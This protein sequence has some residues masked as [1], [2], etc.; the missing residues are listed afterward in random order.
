VDGD[1]NTAYGV[2]ALLSNQA[3]NNGTAFGH[4]AMSLVNNQAT[5]FTNTSIAFGYEALRGSVSASANTGSGNSAVGYQSLFSNSSGDFNTAMG[6][7]SLYTNSTGNR[8]TGFG[9]LTLNDNSTGSQNTATGWQTL[10]SNT[11]GE[12][13][14]ACGA[15][16]MRFSS[17]G[18]RNTAYGVFAL[19]ENVAG[20]NGTA[21]GYNAM[22]LYNNSAVPF[23]N[24]NTA[25]GFEAYMGGAV[26]SGF[27]TGNHNTAVGHQALR[28]NLSG[29]YNVGIGSYALQFINT[30]SYNTGVGM[31]TLFDSGADY[32]T[33]LGYSAG[34]AYNNWSGCTF[35]GYNSESNFDTYENATAIGYNAIVTA[36]DR[37]R[38]G[39][40]SVG[41]IGGQVGWTTFSD[42]RFKTNISED[43]S[44]LA[45]ILKLR[46]VS[47]NTDIVSLNTFIGVDRIKQIKES[48][49]EQMPEYKA[50]SQQTIR[51]T[52]FIAQE[53]E[54]AAKELGFD[55]S[56]VDA[57][58]NANDIYGIR[59][60]EFVVPLV[61]AMQEQQAHIEEQTKRNSQ[62]Q[63]QLENL[64]KEI[65]FLKAKMK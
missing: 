12:D 17:T 7:H 61:K 16:T 56:G 8:N 2:S 28:N 51:H 25:I 34:S 44:G 13:N 3:G 41:S 32:L 14:T 54:M 39:N 19:R 5:S 31:Y 64:I 18:S 23:T 62:L 15:N 57:P 47:Y 4:G 53:V 40:T 48:R 9:Y 65:E 55:F 21:I 63:Q 36:S 33:A 20:S 10:N 49:G 45:F 6:Y 30:G 35:L 38:I 26:N 58:R 37:V 22:S 11:T 29:N 42:G 43:I 60:A 27:N 1:R 24:F 50:G 59:Y 52:G 46:P